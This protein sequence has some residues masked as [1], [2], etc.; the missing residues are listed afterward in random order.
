MQI[1]W[2]SKEPCVYSV[3]RHACAE[4]EDV[5]FRTGVAQTGALE[6][7]CIFPGNKADDSSCEPEAE[8]SQAGTR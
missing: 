1:R 4:T 3:R 8:K 6:I 5:F 2:I 7:C